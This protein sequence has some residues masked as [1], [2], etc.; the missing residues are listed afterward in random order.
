M[1]EFLA[2]LGDKE[3]PYITENSEVIKLKKVN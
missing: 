1:G 3:G 2:N